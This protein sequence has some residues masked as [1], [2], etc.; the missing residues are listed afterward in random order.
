[1]QLKAASS[2]Y[3]LSSLPI[4]MN[5]IIWVCVVLVVPLLLAW[6]SN[7]IDSTHDEEIQHDVWYSYQRE[8]MPVW[9]RRAATASEVS[10]GSAEIVYTNQMRPIF[11][12]PRY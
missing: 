1:M 3:N 6:C 2:D 8:D 5:N 10:N 7:V 9:L 11:L 4:E 12:S